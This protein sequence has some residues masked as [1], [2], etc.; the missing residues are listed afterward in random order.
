MKIPYSKIP[1]TY[2]EQ[3]SRLKTRGLIIDNES[4][5]LHLLENIG[6]YRL[7]GYW[8]PLLKDKTNHLFKETANFNKAFLLYCFDREL[9]QLVIS[10]L[11]K[12]EIAIRA[13]MIYILSHKHGCFWFQYPDLFKNKLKHSNTL[14]KISEEY[15]KSDQD[16]VKSFKNKYSD[17]FPPAWMIL[18]VTSF[19]SLSLLYSNLKDSK[20][21]REI[22]NYFGISDS[23]FASW[24]HSIVYLRNLCAHHSRL[25]NRTLSIQPFVPR[26]PHRTWLGHL[27]VNNNKAF[28]MLSIVRYL[29]QTVNPGTNFTNKFLLLLEKYPNI[30]TNAMGFPHNWESEPLW[31]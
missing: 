25:W 19:G 31:Q 5:T 24:I 15:N 12:I 6:Y 13:K 2:S 16:F 10:E 27:P 22:A 20:E 28:F 8:Y 1:L 30:D 23:V 3:L 18:E 9:R 29:L 7:S 21:K 17:D 11:E 26:N 4:K 14:Q